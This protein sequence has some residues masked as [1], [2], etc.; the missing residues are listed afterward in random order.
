MKLFSLP[1]YSTICFIIILKFWLK[2][3]QLIPCKLFNKIFT[4]FHENFWQSGKSGGAEAAE[5]DG[6]GGGS[7]EADGAVG[8]EAGRAEGSFS[9]A[10]STESEFA[11]KTQRKTGRILRFIIIYAFFYILMFHFVKAILYLMQK[12]DK[13][14]PTKCLHVVRVRY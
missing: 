5:L 1:F 10:G 13:I 11:R 14:I 6:C 9:Q 3:W 12:N 7:R 4:N 2:F 8:E